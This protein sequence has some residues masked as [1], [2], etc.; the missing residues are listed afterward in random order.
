TATASNADHDCRHRRRGLLAGPGR[1]SVPRTPVVVWD[2]RGWLCRGL[3]P[4]DDPREAA[5]GLIARGIRRK[6]IPRGSGREGS[7]EVRVDRDP[8]EAREL[9]A[10]ENAS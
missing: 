1:A 6:P 4:A 3:E 8:N 2:R 9:L 10:V 5:E 7:L